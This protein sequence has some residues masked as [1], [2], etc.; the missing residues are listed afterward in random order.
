MGNKI[1][2]Y[3]PDYKNLGAVIGDTKSNWWLMLNTSKYKSGKKKGQYK[4]IKMHTV[5]WY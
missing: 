4:Y 3:E 5:Q 2:T 1:N